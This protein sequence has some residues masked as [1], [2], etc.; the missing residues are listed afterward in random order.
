MHYP[1]PIE[2]AAKRRRIVAIVVGLF[3]VAGVVIYLCRSDEPSYRGHSLSYW[4]ERTIN[5]LAHLRRHED[6]GAIDFQQDSKE[7]ADAVRAIGTNAIPTLLKFVQAK[8]D[9]GVKTLFAF[10]ARRRAGLP[11]QVPA[12]MGMHLMAPMGFGM[13]GTNAL[14]AVPA[15][16]ALTKDSS[17][18][19]RMCAFKCLV[20]IAPLDRKLLVP[21]L[22]P[23]GN[24]P[25]PGNRQEAAQH[26]Q[27][28]LISLTPEEAEKLGVFKAFPELRLPDRRDPK[29]SI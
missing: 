7:S 1:H 15:L 3:L 23:F 19:V 18:E 10:L 14:P 4:L 24:D 13:L 25:D 6:I 17:P 12:G 16:T 29:F 9:S 26:M 27:W 11:P 5:P 28:L 2:I 8:N 21:I 20:M 22:V